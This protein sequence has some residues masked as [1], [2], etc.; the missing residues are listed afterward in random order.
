MIPSIIVVTSIC[1]LPNN[2]GYQIAS[3]GKLTRHLYISTIWHNS[4]CTFHL[5]VNTLKVFT[6]KKHFTSTKIDFIVVIIIRVSSSVWII[7]ISVVVSSPAI[8]ASTIIHEESSTIIAPSVT[9]VSVTGKLDIFMSSSCLIF[10]LI[11]TVV[12]SR[13]MSYL[14]T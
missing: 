8:R 13:Q 9:L 4:I 12:L 11:M 3:S 2:I 1:S 14:P 5:K 7:S 6:Q 10:D